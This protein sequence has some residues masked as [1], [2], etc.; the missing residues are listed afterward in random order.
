MFTENRRP[1]LRSSGTATRRSGHFFVFGFSVVDVSMGLYLRRASSSSSSSSS[2]APN[3]GLFGDGSFCARTRSLPEPRARCS[4][5]AMPLEW[6][7]YQ[8]VP[9]HA[10]EDLTSRLA[11]HP[12]WRTKVVWSGRAFLLRSWHRAR[13]WI[14]RKGARLLA[15]VAWHTV[16]SWQ[17][18]TVLV[19]RPAARSCSRA[20]P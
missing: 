18:P 6:A 1:H 14:L 5:S 17:S 4:Q 13:G 7:Y 2:L 16:R 19:R 15:R 20:F 8:P 10:W 3:R 9:G 12:R 11:W